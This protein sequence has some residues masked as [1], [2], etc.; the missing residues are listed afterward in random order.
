MSIQLSYSL[1]GQEPVDQVFDNPTILIGS[2]KSNHVIV[3]SPGIEPIHAI[4]E[5]FAANDWRVTDLGSDA[6]LKLNGAT[7][8]VE[9]KIKVGDRIVVG[10]VEILIKEIKSVLAPTMFSGRHPLQAPSEQAALGTTVQAPFREADTGKNKAEKSFDAKKTVDSKSKSDSSDEARMPL[11]F[12]PRDATPNGAT[13]EVVCFWNNTVLDI[14][15]Y[16]PKGAGKYKVTIGTPP[17]ADFFMGSTKTIDSY[18]LA[19]V[20]S[21]GYAIKLVDD[22]KAR[23]RRGGKVEEVE[24]EGVIKLGPRDIAHVKYGS[25]NYFFLYIK[26]PVIDM[27]AAKL[28]D[29]L[30]A[31]LMTIGL[32]FY[33]GLNVALL[34]IDAEEKEKDKDD[35]WSI[36]HVP[37]KKLPDPVVPKPKDPIVKIE[38]IK[39]DPPKNVPPPPV[40]KPVK[41]AEAKVVEVVNQP[42]PVEKPV[43]KNNNTSQTLSNDNAKKAPQTPQAVQKPTELEKLNSVGMPTTGAKTPDFKLAG[44][45]TGGKQGAAGGPKGS[46]NE[47]KGGARKG[48]QKADVMGVEGVNNNLASGVNLDKLGTGVGKVL[49]KDGAGALYTKFS[50]SA[51][52]A[53]GGMGSA[54]KTYG[55]GGVGSGSS[56]GI[57]GSAGAINNFGSGAG[58]LLSGQGGKGGLGGDGLGKGFGGQR[59]RAGVEVPPGDPMVSG[60]LTAQEVAQVIKTHLNEIRHCYERLLQRSPNSSGKI[61][62][63]FVIAASGLVSTVNIQDSSI[64]DAPMKGCVN[65]V[66]RRWKFPQPRGGQPV[67]V[68]YPFVFNPV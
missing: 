66:I 23:I 37:E 21:N 24:N 62:V 57:A 49:S 6:G 34:S 44:P 67:N 33:V 2:L 42:K 27:S 68:N 31:M 40:P 50:S 5:E 54:S 13:L 56:L 48:N 9:A 38:E 35:I 41:P 12:N 52:G 3:S 18:S 8:N 26:P 28:R 7:V 17:L 39:Q 11:L 65:G 36:V 30:F 45:N 55:L 58:G 16:Y 64:S 53:G 51:G 46:G 29:P 60:G 47:K 20:S 22:M 15:H 25:L 43:D 14:E 1:P 4:L 63:N 10:A 59:G 32:L 61:T 19:K